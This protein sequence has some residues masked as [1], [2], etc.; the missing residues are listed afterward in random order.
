M[1]PQLHPHRIFVLHAAAHVPVAA[2]PIFRAVC[3]SHFPR[4][5]TV[6]IVALCRPCVCSRIGAPDPW[7]ACA[8]TALHAVCLGQ[9]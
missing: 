6:T 9:C 5:V 3:P 8:Q 2:R 7:F 4:G 1:W